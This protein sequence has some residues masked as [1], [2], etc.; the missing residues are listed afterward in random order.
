[1]WLLIAWP[2]KEFTSTIPVSPPEGLNLY[3][4]KCFGPWWRHQMKAI[5]ALLAICA[6]NSPVT[7]ECPAQR[8]VTQ[9]FDVFFDLRPNKRLSQQWWG[10]LFETPLYPLWRHSNS[11]AYLHFLSFPDIEVAHMVE[12]PPYWRQRADDIKNRS[13][14]SSCPACLTFFW[15]KSPFRYEI[16]ILYTNSASDSELNWPS[17]APFTN[18]DQL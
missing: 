17:V 13:L 16:V 15:Y 5:F 2:H 7:G 6:G 14:Q 3:I 1:M 10:W 11:K 9:S 8:P 12:I 4:L 18:M